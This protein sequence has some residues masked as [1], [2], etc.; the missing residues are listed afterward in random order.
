MGPFA[1]SIPSYRLGVHSQKRRHHGNTQPRDAESRSPSPYIIDSDAETQFSSTSRLPSESIN[2]LSHSPNTLHQLAVAGLSPE[3]ELPSRVH[4]GF[5]H[6]PLPTRSSRRR[7]IERE[8]TPYSTDG[9]GSGAETDSTIASQRSRRRVDVVDE[10]YSARMRH[11]NTMAAIM[12]RCLRDGDIPRAKRAFGLL[13]R[14]RDVDVRIDNLWAIGSEILMRDGEEDAIFQPNRPSSPPQTVASPPPSLLA[15]S[16]EGSQERLDVLS[17]PDTDEGRLDVLENDKREGEDDDDAEERPQKPQRWGN[18]AN[19]AQ[20]KVYLETLIQ[21]H[22]YDAHRPHL[23]SGVDFWPALFGIE[24]YNLD[25]AFQSSLHDIYTEYGFPSLSPPPSRSPSPSPNVEYEDDRMDI[26]DDD[27]EGYGLDS[28]FGR[29]RRRNGEEEEEEAHNRD[30]H[31]AT[32]ALRASTQRAALEL[33]ARMDGVLENVPYTTHAEL[34][35]LRAHVALFIGDLFLPSRVV[36]RYASNPHSRRL[37]DIGINSTQRQRERVSLREA[38]RRLRAHVRAP[39]EHVALA[40]RAEE[41]EKALAFFRRAARA[42][43]RLEDWILRVLDEEGEEGYGEGVR[44]QQ[45]GW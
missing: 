5:P 30:R 20:V 26:D 3:D 45:S 33:A 40:R 18:A 32:D 36:Q 2:P 28:V 17:N 41:Q 27:D 1:L 38:E 9:G 37:P 4:P 23:T 29:G 15:S 44:Q 11:L 8:T 16:R 42:G 6:K 34:L 12:H 39:D 13:V 31:Y 22:P 25:A 14:T 24:I 10:K 43:G 35:R 7:R 21:Q 19:L